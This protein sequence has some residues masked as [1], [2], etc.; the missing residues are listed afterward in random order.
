MK[1]TK[2]WILISVYLCLSFADGALTYINTP[3]LSFEGNPLVAKLGLGWGAL[4]IA[5]IAVFALYFAT[6]Y[7]NYFKYKTV[8]TNETTYTRYWSQ[9]TFDRP[10][11]F[12]KGFILFPK[13]WKPYIAAFGFC[14]LPAAIIA[15]LIL[16][17]E[18]LAT[19]FDIAGRYQ[20]YYFKNTYCFG[21]LD[22][23]AAVVVAIA[24]IFYWFYIEYKKQL[25]CT[26]AE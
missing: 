19:T 14:M 7:Y 10:D 12:W 22:V 8:F 13:H 11:M 15:R 21:R 20:Y 26:T 23:L 17:L 3:D 18:W 16:V 6:A 25:I 2:F 4:A 1:K 24:G 9:I 5:N